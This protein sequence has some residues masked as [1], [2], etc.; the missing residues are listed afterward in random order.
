MRALRCAGRNCNCLDRSER[1]WTREI[2]GSP[3]SRAEQMKIARLL[4]QHG[5]TRVGQQSVLSGRR[6]DLKGAFNVWRV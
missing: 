6:R 3:Q 1:S 5:A 4:E 2:P